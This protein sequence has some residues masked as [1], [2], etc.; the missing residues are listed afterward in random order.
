MTNIV[1]FGEM[2]MRL[3]PLDHLRF[4]Q[5]NSFEVSYSGAE[6]NTLA[7]LQ[8]WGL[9]TQFVTKL[10][11]NDFGNKAISEV[12]RY[13]V[14]SEH[15]IK[16][17]N[18]LGIYFLEKGSAIRHSKVIYDRADSAVAN[19][20]QGEIDWEKVFANASWFHWSGITPGIS[21]EAARECLHACKI[22]RKMNIKISC[23]LNYRSTLWKW[24]KQP[25]EVLPEML[26][27]TN[28][29]LADL[30]TLNK[31]L[32]KQPIDPDY[33]KPD[34]LKEYYD[35]ILEACPDLE[36]LPTTLRYSESASHQKIGGIMYASGDLITSEVKEILPV[37]DRLGTGDAFMAGILYGLNMKMDYQEVLD[38]AVATSAYKHTMSGDINVASLEEIYAI[39]KGD[40]S[41]LIKR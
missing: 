2:L 11:D 3:S 35:E 28:V 5:A 36:F 40:L 31:M 24:G 38:F 30:A 4:F 6:F 1:A 29:I 16:G 10:P 34:K 26:S 25:D 21:A 7:S 17:D 15:I 9:S 37:V 18:R 12:S 33:R 23:D 27:I 14:G 22:A 32:G 41:A 13:Q 19:I 39:M 20:K 8:R